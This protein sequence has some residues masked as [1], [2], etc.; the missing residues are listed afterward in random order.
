MSNTTIFTIVFLISL[1]S[2]IAL[3]K[4]LIP[5]I[6]RKRFGQKILEC[7]PSWHKSKE[8]TPTMGGLAFVIATIIAFAFF[9]FVGDKKEILCT[10]NI[11]VYALLNAFIGIIDDLAKIR[12]KRNEGLSAK[13]KFLLQSIVAILFLILFGL[14][15]GIDT[16]LIIPF[17]NVK[18]ELGILFYVLAFFMLSGF[19]NAVN[20]TDGVDG[21]ATSVTISVA[22]LFLLTSL[23][24]FK[25]TSL[26]FLSSTLL[27]AMLGFLIF[28]FYPAKIFMG[29][30][31][32]L[33]LGA[34]VVSLAF[35]CNNILLVLIYGFVF[36]CE[37][38]SD[39][40]QIAYY[41]I[42]KGK[43]I[44][45]M[46]PLH[47]HFEK[48]GWSEVKIVLVFSLVNVVFCAIAYVCMVKLWV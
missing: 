32:S 30:T 13:A 5:I 47:H 23:T 27:G 43:R 17:F 39:I 38:L 20:L 36:L 24:I 25:S 48:C 29:D 14:T 7:G 11:I 33:F 10:L 28:N 19:V 42:S 40:L 9:C 45:K 21:L 18:V 46:A 37:A 34:M 12:N 44:F 41:K 4:I 3:T 15:V 35:V 2:T 16:S 31:G 1:I 22:L 6:K 8:G 26:V